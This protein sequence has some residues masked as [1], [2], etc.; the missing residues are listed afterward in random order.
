MG[1]P[2]LYYIIS[3]SLISNAIREILDK[4]MDKGFYLLHVYFIFPF[5][6]IKLYKG[7]L[8]SKDKLISRQ[9]A[10]I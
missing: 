5:H 2:E 3:K 7:D 9:I 1:V 10:E 4:L 8:I 6:G